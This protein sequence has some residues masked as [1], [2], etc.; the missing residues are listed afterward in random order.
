MFLGLQKKVYPLSSKT[1]PKF[2]IMQNGVVSELPTFIFRTEERGSFLLPTPVAII[3]AESLTENMKFRYTKN[4]TP[5]KISRNGKDGSVGLYRLYRMAT[6]RKIPLS[7]MEEMMG[8]PQ[9]WTE[10]KLLE[11]D[12]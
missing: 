3:A 1:L 9:G 12:K 2:G 8:V 4:G 6:G 5:R 11:M 7:I 10:L